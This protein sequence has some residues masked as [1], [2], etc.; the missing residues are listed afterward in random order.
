MESNYSYNK[1]TDVQWKSGFVVLSLFLLLVL[2]NSDFYQKCVGLFIFVCLMAYC[3]FLYT[4]FLRDPSGILITNS[5]LVL[6]FRKGPQKSFKYDEI[7]CVRKSNNPFFD[8]VKGK[9][10]IKIRNSDEKFR[11]SGNIQDFDNLLK[12]LTDCGFEIRK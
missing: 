8:Y 10:E 4:K 7:E 9:L 5:E 12:S 2:A 11:I 1:W 6:K 3:S